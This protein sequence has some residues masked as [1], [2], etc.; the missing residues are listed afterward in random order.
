VLEL[1]LTV[2]LASA[3]TPEADA[4]RTAQRYLDA[5]R[6]IEDAKGLRGFIFGFEKRSPDQMWAHVS[7]GP[8]DG[9]SMPNRRHGDRWLI[10]AG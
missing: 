9:G 5:V 10:S 7:A 3:T 2:A 8:D 1:I 4:L 6:A